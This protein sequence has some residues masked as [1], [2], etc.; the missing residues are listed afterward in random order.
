MLDV[1]G[2]HIKDVMDMDLDE[3]IQKYNRT[4]R[5]AELLRYML[6]ADHGLKEELEQKTWT[7]VWQL[8]Y[9][10]FQAWKR[11]KVWCCLRNAHDTHC[12]FDCPWRPPCLFCALLMFRVLSPD[13]G[14]VTI[15]VFS[16][17]DLRS[18]SLAMPPQPPPPQ[19]PSQYSVPYQS[20]GYGQQY[21]HYGQRYGQLYVQR[22]LQY[23]Q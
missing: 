9:Q 3:L 17:L 11:H 1:S 18:M 5:A 23:Q 22:P 10:E 14:P 6:E 2:F 7:L 12:L 19:Y 21:G 8:E 4:V 16:A 20:P 15:I 13:L